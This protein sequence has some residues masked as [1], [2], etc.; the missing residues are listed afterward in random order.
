MKVGAFALTRRIRR[1][2]DRHPHPRSRLRGS[3][4]LVWAEQ[5]CLASAEQGRAPSPASKREKG[6][7]G[8]ALPRPSA[9][10]P[11]PAET[12]PVA[13]RTPSGGRASHKRV[14]GGV[15]RLKFAPSP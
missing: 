9:I 8:E 3:R 15:R 7:D 10:G 12:G 5:G 6:N 13:G 1:K 11:P 14:F 4:S 2:L